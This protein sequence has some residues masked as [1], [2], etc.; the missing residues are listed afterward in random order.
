MSSYINIKL[1]RSDYFA[2]SDVDRFVSIIYNNFPELHSSPEIHNKKDIKSIL[3]NENM[4]GFIITKDSTI[5]GYLFGD[6]RIASYSTRRIFYISYIYIGSKYRDRGL[7]TKLINK[8]IELANRLH[9][10]GVML[11]YDTQNSSLVKFY[12]NK[13]FMLDTMLRKYTRFDIFYKDL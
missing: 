4:Y 13:G 6:M 12:Q 7:G 10:D 5:I 11:T 2:N 9:L 8:S 1:V 3:L